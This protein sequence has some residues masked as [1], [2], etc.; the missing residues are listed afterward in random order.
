M[1]N[2]FFKDIGKTNVLA[3][4]Y[5][6]LLLWLILAII[7]GVWAQNKKIL[8]PFVY[9]HFGKITFNIIRWLA[10]ILTSLYLRFALIALLLFLINIKFEKV[11][12]FS[13]M[14]FALSVSLLWKPK[15]EHFFNPV[16]KV[17][18]NFDDKNSLSEKWEIKT[19]IPEIDEKFGKP[20]PDLELKRTGEA[21]TNSFVWVKDVNSR[22]GVIE[23]DFY[24]EPNSVFNIV[25]FADKI[26]DNWYMARF[27]SRQKFS[28]GFLIKN[29]GKGNNWDNFILSGTITEAKK[30]FRA[31]IEFNENIV[32]MYKDGEIIAQFKS[33]QIFGDSLGM[34]NEVNDV[35]VDNFLFI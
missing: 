33:P 29:K 6:S 24:L 18:D 9:K 2:F 26:K 19:G 17:S 27:D 8:L 22:S 31:R 21:G 1:L 30:W 10:Y 23:C 5:G 28:D 14:I 20:A 34:F 15:K 11:I 7:G 35:H 32:K 13:I 25:F 12:T 4:F 16:S 3:S